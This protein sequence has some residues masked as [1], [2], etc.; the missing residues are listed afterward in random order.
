MLQCTLF[1][2]NDNFALC[3]SKYTDHQCDYFFLRLYRTTD[4]AT[5]K[6]FAVS[7]M[8]LCCLFVD[9]LNYAYIISTL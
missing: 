8:G 6:V 1:I 9:G 2:L 5:P 3:L 7:V 4:L